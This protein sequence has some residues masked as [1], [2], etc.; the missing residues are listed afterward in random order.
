MTWSFSMLVTGRSGSGKSNLL[1][2][3]VLGDKDEYVQRG[4]KGGSCYIKCDDL[5]ICGYHPDK[6]NFSYIPPERIPSIRI[7]SPERSKLFIFEDLC[8]ASDHIQNRIGQFFGNRHHRNISCI[9]I[10]QKYHKVDT[11]KRENSTHLVLFNYGSSI[12]DVSKIVGRYTDNVKAK[13]TPIINIDP[14]KAH[15][16]DQHLALQKIYYRPEGLYQNVKGLWDACKKVG[17][18]FPF[19]DVKKWLD[20]QAMYQIFHPSLKHI[21]L[22]QLL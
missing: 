15:D 18:S 11:F 10:T 22:C 1:A 12:Q 3:L 16:L 7:F 6:P 9:Y 17:Y 20:R 2:N 8:L 21:P 13:Q 5:I 19:I 14:Q 4:K